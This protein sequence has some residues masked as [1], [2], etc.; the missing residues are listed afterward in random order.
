[1]REGN[2]FTDRDFM[3][4]LGVG[5]PALKKMEE[6]PG[7]LSISQFLQLAE[8]LGQPVAALVAL[9]VGDGQGRPGFARKEALPVVAGRKHSYRQRGEE[10]SAK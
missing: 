8:L 1:M 4:V 9:A 2:R 5:H 3:R 6:N 10:A 7:L